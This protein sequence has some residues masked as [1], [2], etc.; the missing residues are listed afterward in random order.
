M[1][2]K[3]IISIVVVLVIL[4]FGMPEVL[5][6]NVPYR[7]GALVTDFKDKVFKTSDVFVVP[8]LPKNY[9]VELFYYNHWYGDQGYFVLVGQEVLN[10]YK[11]PDINSEVV[12]QLPKTTRVRILYRK[13]QKDMINGDLRQWVFLSDEYGDAYLGWVLQDGLIVSTDFEIYKDLSFSGFV[14]VR[15]EYSARVE[16]NPTGRFAMD[17]RAVGQGLFLKGNVEGQFYGYD[18]ILW[19]KKDDQDFI[20]DFFL[21][22]DQVNLAQEQ[23]FVEDSIT[24]N[25][26]LLPE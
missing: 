12:F 5:D 8:K 25:L 13:E 22:K 26:F 10:A 6:L 16:V 18:D 14:Y 19:A 1:T 24:M 11:G 2:K 20:Y 3:R 7:I 15:G 9:D 4:I 23:R 21:L 17:W